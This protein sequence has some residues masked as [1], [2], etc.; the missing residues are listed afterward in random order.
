M[1]D[2]YS[3]FFAG[4][5]VRLGAEAEIPLFGRIAELIAWSSL[6]LLSRPG[7]LYGLADTGMQPEGI[8]FCSQGADDGLIAQGDVWGGLAWPY[9]AGTFG[10]GDFLT[11]RAEVDAVRSASLTRSLSATN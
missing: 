6:E 7:K 10:L 2:I 11:A 9:T 4:D 3:L 1:S 8:S 5:L